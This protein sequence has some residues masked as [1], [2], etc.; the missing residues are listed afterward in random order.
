[1][2]QRHIPID[3]YKKPNGFLETISFPVECT[4]ES[5]ATKLDVQLK[6]LDEY[7]IKVTGEI[8]GNLLNVCLDDGSFDYK[9]ELFGKD[10]YQ[11]DIKNLVLNFD[12]E[13]YKTFR[14]S[15]RGS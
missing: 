5:E 14:A 10:T 9:F 2:V 13:D 11:D 1:M 4:D 8:T 15:H 3:E 7:G 12:E 6:K